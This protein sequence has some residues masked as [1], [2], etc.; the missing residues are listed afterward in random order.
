MFDALL[1][2]SGYPTDRLAPGPTASQRRCDAFGQDIVTA[3]V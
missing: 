3:L 2:Q 1:L